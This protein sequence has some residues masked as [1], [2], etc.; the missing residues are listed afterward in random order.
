MKVLWRIL[1]ALA[2]L[3]PAGISQNA[4]AQTPVTNF[5]I[6]NGWYYKEANGQGGVGD[7][8]YSITD[9]GGIFFY[10]EFIYFG[11]PNVL[12]FPATRRFTMD[13]F[14]IQGTQKVGLQWRPEINSI[15]YLNLFDI[16]HDLGHDAWLE[17]VKQVPPPF[18]T[19]PDTG[20][21]FEQVKTRHLAFLDG[22]TAIKQLF[23]ANP[24][25][26][27]QYGLPLSFADYPNVYV[28][29][30][31]RA[32]FQ[33][34]KTAQPWASAGQVTI[35]NGI[36]VAKEAKILPQEAVTPEPGPPGSAAASP[37]PTPT[38]PAQPV[39]GAP[40]SATA[41]GYGMQIN[42]ND[43]LE[44]AVALTRAAGFGWIKVQIRWESLE[45]PKGTI[46]W[47]AIDPSVQ[48]AQA[49][50]LR[51]MMSVV[52][53]PNWSRPRDTD[54]GVPGPPTNPQDF[55]DF[56]G[57]IAAR[58][59]GK[60][61][62]IEVWNEQNLW[63]EW[64]GMG[65][66]INAQQYVNMLSLAYRAI[67]AQD[68][69]IVVISGAPTPT[70]VNDGDTAYDD[71][72]YLQQ[73][74]AAGLKDVSDAIGLHPSGYNNPPDDTPS[75]KTVNTTTFKGHGSFYFRR[76]EEAYDIMVANGDGNKRLWFTEF[77][78]ASSPNP[79]PEYAYARD[80]SE[81][82][83]AKY[84]VRAYEIGKASGKVGVM[85]LWNLN[86]APG[87]ES[88]DRYAKEAFGI[89]KRDWSPRQAYAA[90]T[91]MPK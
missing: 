4:A 78:W 18:D 40:A 51:L 46:N 32:V 69:S 87:A 84:I 13:G 21:T 43:G 54:F 33:Q 5:A 39:A 6:P 88:N 82:D 24:D 53:A 35:A 63:Y 91:A 60:I 49:T 73:M 25:W 16:L 12:G 52:T 61:G 66:K 56:V 38:A 7:S 37:T 85:F 57:A 17:Q 9:E 55:A 11:G 3:L 23:L 90:L 74:Y 30:G 77:G 47:G 79:Y 67:K 76:F 41:F 44:R 65:R 50:G 48:A 15:A 10:R 42:Q 83:Q 72:V 59:K 2:V 68:P 89:L 14:T 34:W 36:D 19:T 70:G 64:G 81:A 31:Q 1:V 28:V 20:L 80:N 86:F 71:M 62:A 8:G 26:L 75:Q 45:G 27:N 58:H 29:R 22:N